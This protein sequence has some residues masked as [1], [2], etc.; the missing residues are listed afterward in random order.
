[1]RAEQYLHR[2]AVQGSRVVPALELL[3][4]VYEQANDWAQALQTNRRLEASSG[5]ARQERAAHYCCE[6]ADRQAREGQT[7][8]A[9]QRLREA[10]QLDPRSVRARLQMAALLEKRGDTAAA[11]VLLREVVDLDARFLTEALPGLRRCHE[12]EQRL[13]AYASWLASLAAPAELPPAAVIAQA[14]LSRE[15]GLDP[16]PLLAASL[17]HKPSWTVLQALLERLELAP[18]HRLGEALQGMRSALQT[19]AGRLPR[20][21]CDHCGLMPSLLF[22]QCPNCKRWGSIAPKINWI[23]EP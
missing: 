7:A 2:L 15:T 5:E 13:D 21:R 11:I 6:Q 12:Q 19:A 14:E 3:V 8:A 1:D 4:Q 16:Q 9:L 10:R 23:G 17:A 18:G 22:W 20:Y